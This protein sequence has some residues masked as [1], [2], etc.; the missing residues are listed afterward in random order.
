MAIRNIL[1]Q[2]L[3]LC[4]I[5][6]G[7]GTAEARVG[8]KIKH[9]DQVIKVDGILSEEAW[10][11]AAVIDS[12]ERFLPTEGGEPP[13]KTEIRFMQSKSHLFI[14]ATISDTNYQPLGRISPRERINDDDQI[15]IYIDT[16]GDG[17][18]GYIFYF[19]ALGIQQDIRYSHGNWFVEYNTIYESMGKKTEAGYVL[20]IA[21][22][23]R[24]LQYPNV[25]KADWRAMVTRKVPHLGSK[26]SFPKLQRNHTRMFQQA[27][28]MT[29]LK[30][31]PVGSGL[32]VQ[33]ALALSQGFQPNDENDL[34]VDEDA[35]I[36]EQIQPSLNLRWGI[37]PDT[38]LTVA[39]NPD[40]SQVEGDPTNQSQSAFCFLLP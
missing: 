35:K 29:G 3:S 28:P 7:I 14:S 1:V 13:G 10:T 21:I 32:A 19:N 25:E 22:P 40:Y 20:E 6:I 11:T 30:P 9:T 4:F 5:G 24:S 17:R 15:G 26:Y 38:G 37:T 33:P 39:F 2:T 12:F 36:F 31:A 34:V 18:T 16:I 27:V 8:S 23:Y